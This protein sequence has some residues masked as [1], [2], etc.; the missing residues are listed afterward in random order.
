MA[1]TAL[2]DGRFIEVNERFV[3][4]FGHSRDE[5][6]VHTSTELGL[7]RR[8]E[9]RRR[10]ARTLRGGNPVQDLAVAYRKRPGETGVALVSAE[11]L[12]IAGE[13][14]LVS[15]IRD[16]AAYHRAVGERRGEST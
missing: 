3:E 9:D 13:P 8:P 10:M 15:S 11:P 4:V 5:V 16:L 2:A 7:W 1:I 12:E 6:L 14:C